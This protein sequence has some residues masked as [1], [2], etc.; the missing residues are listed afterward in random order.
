MVF[1]QEFAINSASG[2]YK[3]VRVMLWLIKSMI[4]ANK[5]ANVDQNLIYILL[6]ALYE[7]QKWFRYD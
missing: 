2:K 3:K 6:V 7:Q 1:E 5:M 4:L